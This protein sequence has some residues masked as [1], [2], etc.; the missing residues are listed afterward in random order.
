[1]AFSSGSELARQ[2]L[3][4]AIEKNSAPILSSIV[5]DMFKNNISIGQIENAQIIGFL[6]TIEA[7]IKTTGES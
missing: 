1:M 7:K 4:Y 3:T 5:M 6:S 2:Y